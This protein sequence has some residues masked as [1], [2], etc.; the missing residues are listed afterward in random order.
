MKKFIMF[1]TLLFVFSVGV[2]YAA[3]IGNETTKITCFSEDVSPKADFSI[4]IQN[5]DFTLVYSYR[6]N[7]PP[8]IKDNYLL[9]SDADITPYV[10][11]INLIQKYNITNCLSTDNRNLPPKYIMLNVRNVI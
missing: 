8:E 2:T 11:I 5:L 7:D 6:V 1:L 10:Y 9:K 3:D 4:T